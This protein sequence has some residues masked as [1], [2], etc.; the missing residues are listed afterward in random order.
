MVPMEKN[1]YNKYL[2]P[3]FSAVM[4]Y[5]VQDTV[6]FHLHCELNML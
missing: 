1:R 3:E 2:D 4:D 6:H 5:N